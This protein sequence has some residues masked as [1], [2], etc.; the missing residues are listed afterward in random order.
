MEVRCGVKMHLYF[1][2]FDGRIETTIVAGH[3]GLVR[4]DS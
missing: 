4:S 1:R 3:V 2:N